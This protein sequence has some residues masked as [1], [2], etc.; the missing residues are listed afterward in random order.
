MHR[1]LYQAIANGIL[2][3]ENCKSSGNDEWFTRHTDRILGMVKDYMPSGS[4]FDNGTTIDLDASSAD[5]LVFRTAFHHMDENG[6]YDGWT[7]HTVTILP[8]LVFL[9][10]V[11]VSGEDRNM[12]LEYIGDAFQ[13]ALETE[14]SFTGE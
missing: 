12:I 6:S 11:D 8:S 1:K 5:R 13:S 4:G 3:R 7:E 2:A 14:D 9:F 10:N